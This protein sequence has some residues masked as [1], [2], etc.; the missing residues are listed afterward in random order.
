MDVFNFCV[1]QTLHQPF[2][3][4]LAPLLCKSTSVKQSPYA[5]LPAC[6]WA[7][8]T[9]TSFKHL[10]KPFAEAEMNFQAMNKN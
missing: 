6:T 7:F 9:H 2:P 4:V 3:S 10:L 5:P 8:F 1:T